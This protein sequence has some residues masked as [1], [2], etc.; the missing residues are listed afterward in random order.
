MS[1]FLKILNGSDEFEKLV[2]SVSGKRLPMGVIG[3]SQVHKAHYISSL[4]EK[5][6][7]R[8]ALIVCPDEG[9]ATKLCEDINSFCGGAYL[10]PA[11]DFSFRG[12][13]SKSHEF[14]QK[15]LSV[16]C[17]ILDGECKLVLC[18]I[19]A[20]VQLTIPPCELKKR[21][22]TLCVGQEVTTHQLVNTLLAAGYVRTDLVD[23]VGQFS[24]RGCILD[25][26][27]PD[28]NEPCRVEF[29][30]DEIDSMAH[31]DLESQRRTDVLEKVK[32]TPATEVLFDSREA[33][34]EKLLSFIDT[35]KGK[36]SVK[37]KEKI[38]ED[39]EALEHFTGVGA[40]DKY[41]PLAYKERATVFDYMKDSLLFV[42]ESAT[43]KQKFNTSS[44]LLNEDIRT[45]F[46]EGVLTKGI[47]TFTLTWTQVLKK[48]E[49]NGAI[50]TDSLAR[51]SFDTPVKELVS[52]NARQTS[53]WDGT[54]SFLMDDLKPA[55]HS[56]Y[57]C[58]VMSGTEKS[59]KELAF[60]LE[61][62]GIRARYFPVVPG[63]FPKGL[64]SVIP[65]T[66]SSGIEY[67]REKFSLFTYG[68][69]S[70]KTAKEKK[71]KF[72]TGRGLTSL[73]EISK[74]DYVVHSLHG[75]GVFD[76]IKTMNM[77]G[78]IKD[79]IK[80]NYRG[81][82][83]LY[84]PVTQLDLISK[85]ASPHD[86]DKVIKLN[87]L[88]S[89]EWKK[90]KSKVRAAVKD[91]AKKLTELYAQRLNS[92]GYS[93]SPDMDMQ[94]DFERRFEF[95]ET[96]DQLIAIN[97]IKQ[98]MER[99]SPMDRLL[100]GDVG[101]G[102]TEV[103]LRAAFKCVADG[104][105]CAILVPTTILA[106]Q[107]FQTIKKRF[108]SFPVEVDMISRFRSQSDRTKIK[109][110]LKRGS[111]DIIVGTHAIIAKSVEF[112][113]L[114]LLIVDEEQR[115]GVLQKEKLKEKFPGVDVLTLS[116]TPIPRTLNMAMTGIRDMSL[117]EM[118]PQGRH[119][120]QSYVVP[121]D[122]SILAEAMERELRR[123][124]QV[125]YLFN[126]IDGIESRAAQIKEYLPD[127][128]IGIGHG[129]MSEEELSEVWRQLLENEIDILVCTTII[130]TGVDVP[131]ANTLIIEDADRLGL[132]QLHQIR[133]RVGRSPRRAFAYF[134]YGKHKQLNETARR[135]LEAI[136][137]YTEFGS[138]F[139][140][141]MR[142]LEI[143]GAG[144]VLG[145]QQHGHMEAVGYDMYL[146]ILS[147][148]I[149]EEKTGQQQTE[150]RECVV[151]ISIDA[152]IPETYIDSVKN[153]ISM[154]KRIAE[155][156][157]AEDAMDVTDEFIDRFGDIPPSVK[158]L[159]DVALLRANAAKLGIFEIK[160]QNGMVLAFF[161]VLRPEYV[162]AVAVNLRGRAMISGAKSSAPY[163]SL[164]LQGRS[165]VEAIKELIAVL[166]V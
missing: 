27:P 71:K 108:D 8:T 49:D 50:Y 107:H 163:I 26:F 63:E 81:N 65:G 142:D 113:D 9:S 53:R 132:A 94:S 122:M 91:M 40:P 139:K 165:N 51:G 121:Q 30:G 152:H 39:I 148:A 10:Y 157:N 79:F 11:R 44:A 141:A 28:S 161:D 110:A 100:C 55:I 13:D 162:S 36:G 35:V 42:C 126:R 129:K 47:D 119:P 92:K 101:F 6:S 60:D 160:Q 98:D 58:V 33:L 109:K 146:K 2:S 140:I 45:L 7:D 125:Y 143:R 75:I 150:K 97:E 159:I 86:A 88:G 34:K 105:Q 54:L 78:I 154:Y 130:E 87:K 29:W 32:L 21:S 144:S 67:D 41:L 72:K 153:R 149:N 120:V 4:V 62:E 23:G 43:V 52:I 56:G 158:G 164:K 117:L 46:E 118:A 73:D 111:I 114:G 16:L 64:V 85:Y 133:G 134:T 19:E 128:K 156:E 80:I 115:F 116:A 124:G 48:Y 112:K 15:R 137:E 22:F 127:A 83:V 138:G 3:L 14:E 106:F 69:P 1:G 136:R 38:R 84:L 17:R 74:G 123:G 77:S 68:R 135:R 95:E 155:I 104:K 96:D 31:F 89:D 24:L 90:T 12:S 25:F 102:K 59:A 147:E 18:S 66:V 145:A 76:G 93:F 166:S 82:D 103:A 20:A 131:N 70:A 37:A 151:D 5:L 57:T 61:S 99:P